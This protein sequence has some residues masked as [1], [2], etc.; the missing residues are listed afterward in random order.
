MISIGNFRQYIFYHVVIIMYCNMNVSRRFNLINIVSN[1]TI[2]YI[3]RYTNLLIHIFI[4]IYGV[5]DKID[6]IGISKTVKDTI[7]VRWEKRQ[8]SQMLY[9]NLK[10]LQDFWKYWGKTKNWNIVAILWTDLFKCGSFVFETTANQ[11][12]LTIFSLNL[13]IFLQP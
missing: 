5:P 12:T 7:F 4:Y 2:C 9:L 11:M 13:Q 6:Y 1:V 3:Q 10:H 8:P